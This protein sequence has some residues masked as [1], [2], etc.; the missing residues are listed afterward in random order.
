VGSEAAKTAAR[1]GTQT[2]LGEK[3]ILKPW[4]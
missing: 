2:L 4:F 3:V 1:M